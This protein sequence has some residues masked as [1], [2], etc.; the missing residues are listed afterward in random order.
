M[1]DKPEVTT[2]TKRELVAAVSERTGIPQNEVSDIVQTTLDTIVEALAEG[3]RLEVRNFGVFEVR[4]RD[5][6]TGRNPRTGQIVPIASKRVASFRPGKALKE[7]AQPV[8]PAASP[9]TTEPDP[10]P[11]APSDSDST[12]DQQ[13]LF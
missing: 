12:G 5:A 4:T 7:R 13:S 9:E 11:P 2:A 3:Q 8:H 10:A 6:R 1:P